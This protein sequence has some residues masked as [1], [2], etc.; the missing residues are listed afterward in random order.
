MNTRRPGFTLPEILVVVL[1]VAVLAGVMIPVITNSLRT[2]KRTTC[3]SNLHQIGMAII[4]YRQDNNAYPEPGKAIG[5]LSSAYAKILPK[6]PNC[7][8]DPD[9]NHATYEELYNYWGYDTTLAPTPLQS[10]TDADSVYAPIQA[11][12][13]PTSAVQWTVD[14]P[15]YAVDD[16]VHYKTGDYICIQANTPDATTNAPYD[17]SDWKEYWQPTT[18]SILWASGRPE[19]AFP[20]L[21]NPN[22]PANTIVTICPQHVNDIHNMLVVRVSGEAGTAPQQKTDKEFWALSKMP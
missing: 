7:P 11:A 8:R 10:V 2:G 1:I 17:G 20:G 16:I 5:A 6:E 13:G 19:T 22:A 9:A 18:L 14:T 3:L 15:T 12:S 21:A 4:A